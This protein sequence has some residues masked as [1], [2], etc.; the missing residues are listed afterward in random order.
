ML[1]TN[2]FHSMTV[3]IRSSFHL[4]V[5]SPLFCYFADGRDLSIIRVIKRNIQMNQNECALE[6]IC[7]I[8]ANQ[9]VLVHVGTAVEL[10]TPQYHRTFDKKSCEH[11]A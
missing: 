11:T 4:L 2:L 3:P 10:G 6:D 9:F 1:V 8:S 7:G 5:A